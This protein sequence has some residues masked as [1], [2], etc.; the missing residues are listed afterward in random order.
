M[1]AIVAKNIISLWSFQSHLT[2]LINKWNWLICHYTVAYVG[3]NC[4]PSL[5]KDSTRCR[6][7]L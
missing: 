2:A 1:A 4:N 7:R 6:T 5:F 3:R